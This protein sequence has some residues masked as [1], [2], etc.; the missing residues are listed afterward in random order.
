MRRHRNTHRGSCRSDTLTLCTKTSQ[1]LISGG[2]TRSVRF[3]CPDER[4]FTLLSERR[5]SFP[6]GGGSIQSWA[7]VL[8][9]QPGKM[10]PVRM[11]PMEKL[12][13]EDFK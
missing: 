9:A 4:R 3:P 13:C 6:P 8:A 7:A 10:S 12:D 11:H 2:V 5:R 1:K